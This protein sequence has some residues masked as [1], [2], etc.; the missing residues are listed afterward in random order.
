MTKPH[1]DLLKAGPARGQ[2]RCQLRAP[3]RGMHG[4]ACFGSTPSEAYARWRAWQEHVKS[5]PFLYLGV[6]A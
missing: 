2:W 5:A 1:I 4:A 3:L 6:A